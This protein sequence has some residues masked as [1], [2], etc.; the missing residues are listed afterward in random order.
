M[1]QLANLVRLYKENKT[2]KYILEKELTVFMG[3]HCE[4]YIVEDSAPSTSMSYGVF[5]IPEQR[6]NGIYLMYFVDRSALFNFYSEKE[7]VL[8]MKQ[9]KADQQK[10][11]HEYSNFMKSTAANSVSFN[12][13]FAEYLRLYGIIRASLQTSGTNNDFL[14]SDKSIT[15]M[16]VKF[17]DG[18]ANEQDVENLKI[19]D[20]VPFKAIELARKFSEKS[21]SDEVNVIFNK[22]ALET[23]SMN[24]GRQEVLELVNSETDYIGHK[25]IKYDYL[26]STNQ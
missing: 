16:V 15:E 24:L 3:N 7:F 22:S 14:P 1:E 18:L 12:E 2:T 23:P 11:F 17:E 20:V 13:I 8:A 9:L 21:G 26:P 25:D 4:V 10:V 19:N 6:S 5:V